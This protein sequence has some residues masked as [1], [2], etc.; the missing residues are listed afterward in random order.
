[1][2]RTTILAIPAVFTLVLGSLGCGQAAP[3]P[4]PTKA[5]AATSKAAEPT[6]APAAAPT[7]APEATRPAAA[8]TKAPEP[9]K[10]VA[11]APAKQVD[12]PEKGKAITIIVPWPAGGGADVT[13]RV[14]A[15][16][17]EKELGVPVQV[18]NRGGAG[19]QVGFTEIA[20]SRPD[21]YTIGLM[22]GPPAQLIPLD[23]ERQAAF[24]RDSFEPIGLLVDD[25]A[26][27]T[28]K[29]D[30]QF[31][32]AKELMDYAKANPE[33][34]KVGTSGLQTDDHLS[35]V[36]LDQIAG[37][38]FSI[39]HFEGAAPAMTAFLGGHVDISF[40][41]VSEVPSR[42]REGS[43]RVLGIL[44]KSQSKFLPGVR[45]MEEQGYKAY[46][47]APRGVAVPAGTP[48]EIVGILSNAV[49][50]S[51]QDPEHVKKAEDMF[52]TVRPLDAAE[53]KAY[54]IDYETRIKPLVPL[55]R[56]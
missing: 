37:A 51:V 50:K 12:W 30:S 38:R 27:L 11:A 17:L 15:P 56:K 36:L 31:K 42:V 46:M 13:A 19:G 25:P 29:A 4:T 45:T 14:L 47:S 20:R 21:G 10:P 43:V 53:Y 24:T 22:G 5:P 7:K 41:N 40:A 18:A 32:T 28:V 54:W 48:K 44:D 23:P 26:T 55:A 52:L 8:P 34:V 35:A 16:I 6:K 49:K 9:T 3:P 1:M 39:V 2:K 33:K